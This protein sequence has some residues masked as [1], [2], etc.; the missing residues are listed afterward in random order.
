M[1]H[2]GEVEFFGGIQEIASATVDGEGNVQS[3]LRTEASI[4]GRYLHDVLD[5]A[6][7]TLVLLRKRFTSDAP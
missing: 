6:M 7:L 3:R 2:A 1:N 4:Y 5:P